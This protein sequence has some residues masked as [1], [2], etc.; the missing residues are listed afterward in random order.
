MLQ[1]ES[2]HSSPACKKDDAQKFLTGYDVATE[3]TAQ[4]GIIQNSR[5]GLPFLFQNARTMRLGVRF[6]FKTS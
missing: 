6:I 3:A 2:R 1:P 4:G 5:Y